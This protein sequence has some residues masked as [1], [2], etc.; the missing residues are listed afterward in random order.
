MQGSWMRLLDLRRTSC[1]IDQS[2]EGG[3]IRLVLARLTQRL[4]VLMH[5]L[6]LRT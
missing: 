1:S 3:R 6:D 4:V 2:L 5:E